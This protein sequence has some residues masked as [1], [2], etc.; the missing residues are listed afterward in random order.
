M[1]GVWS[2]TWVDKE[3]PKSVFQFP[4]AHEGQNRA[5]DREEQRKGRAQG[6]VPE[7]VDGA[8]EAICVLWVPLA[9]GGD[10]RLDQDR[11]PEQRAH[12]QRPDRVRQQLGFCNTLS[13]RVSA[14]R[15]VHSHVSLEGRRTEGDS[16]PEAAGAWDRE[17]VELE[18]GAEFEEFCELWRPFDTEDHEPRQNLQHNAQ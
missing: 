17:E 14:A 3:E 12:R 1:A 4:T 18:D 2:L 15:Q 8:V 7:A 10:E 11:E 6:V 9:A 5:H 13:K 16:G